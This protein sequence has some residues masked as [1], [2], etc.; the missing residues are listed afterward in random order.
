MGYASGGSVPPGTPDSIRGEGSDRVRPIGGTTFTSDAAL[1][2][3]PGRLLGWSILESS[4]SAACSVTL[5]DGQS[6]G[7]QV[8]DFLEAASSAS[9]ANDFFDQGIDVQNGVFVH[10]NSGQ[11]KVVIRYRADVGYE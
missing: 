3:L 8:I 7:G 6:T 10:L 4:G 11:A 9:N 1:T 2:S 5:Y